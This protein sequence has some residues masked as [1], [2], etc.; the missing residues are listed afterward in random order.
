M[1]ISLGIL[2]TR[3][4]FRRRV[5][6]LVPI[7]RN[8]IMESIDYG[9]I[10]LD[11]K[12]RVV[13][14]NPFARHIYECNINVIGKRAEECFKR[15][16]DLIQII[17]KNKEHIEYKVSIINGDQYYYASCSPIKND[18]ENVIGRFLI[19]Q[20]ITDRKLTAQK[21]LEEEKEIAIREEREKMARDLDNNIGQILAFINVQSQAITEYI[22][23]GQQQTAF[24]CIE[25]LTEIAQDA[26]GNLREAILIMRGEKISMEKGMAD[27]LTELNM[28]LEFFKKSYG[29]NMKLEYK[30][31]EGFNFADS[32]IVF[33]VLNIIKESI[34]NIAKHSRASSA[35]IS[36]VEDN[37]C[38]YIS[39]KDNGCGFDT[40]KVFSDGKNKYGIKFMK[41]R[42]A[43]I[44][45]D[46]D[47]CS[48][49]G[50]GTEIRL[51]VP[52]KI[53]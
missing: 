4:F 12:N 52:V 11:S 44:G 5:S 34:N 15:W 9:I 39:I 26:H 14:I 32:K 31:A 21:L 24:R 45:A 35:N 48:A 47:I 2:I 23:N 37:D 33:Q 30:A 27:L 13:D 28:Q 18:R 8:R 42:V 20:D 19:I 43:E 22:K 3:S 16:P 25:R 10:V 46:L 49:Y 1:N 38:M 29:I 6:D 53:K 7:A 17:L 40:G 41:E 36:F 50:Q 51:R